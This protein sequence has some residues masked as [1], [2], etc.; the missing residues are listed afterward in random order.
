M[1][2]RHS[3][4]DER[5]GVREKLW[6]VVADEVEFLTPRSEGAAPAD[7]APM[8]TREEAREAPTA[9][10]TQVEDEDLPF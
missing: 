2:A 10:F 9:G 4:E 3:R 5:D 7:E 1:G 6:D 8:K